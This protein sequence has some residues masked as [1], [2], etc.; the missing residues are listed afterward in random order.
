MQPFGPFPPDE[1]RFSLGVAVSGGA[2]SL[3]L[4]WLMRRWRRSM[5]AFVV[6]H[7]LRTESAIEARQ[8][9]D[10]LA[11]LDI[12]VDVLRLEG[13]SLHSRLQEGARKARYA[14]LSEACARYGILD[15]ALGHH[16]RDQAET[17]YLRQAHG[18]TGY[19]LAAMARA[20][21]TGSLRYLRPLLSTE[22]ARLRATLRA[23]DIQWVE[24]PSNRNRAFERVR[25][26]QAL[27]AGRLDVAAAETRRHGH[28]R[29]VREA[30][31]ADALTH[32]HV[33]P[34]GFVVMPAIP[35]DIVLLGRL[36]QM[37]SGRDYAPSPSALAR[38]ID[39]PAPC[40]LGGAM[41]F[42]A[43][44]LG[45]GWCLAREPGAIR[46]RCEVRAGQKWDGRF[47]IGETRSGSGLHV[48][49]IGAE[50]RRFR[51]A[52]L[53]ARILSGL[54]G[55]WRGA[56]LLATPAFDGGLNGP[57]TSALFRFCPRQSLSAPSLW[58]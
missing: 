57:D 20:R 2:D 41:L 48:A 37:V 25:I 22:P 52:Q 14:V 18:S 27:D 15:L 3:C 23:Q 45:E 35:C 53:P 24:D 42:A 32:M 6:D 29:N 17:Y 49:A 7:G 13:L 46:Q 38:L 28:D 43:G 5:R 9:A 21:E 26:R 11:G 12:P 16:A 33:D 40:T 30:A 4:A 51:T 8:T 19:G 54:P 50:S 44:R 36:W 58:G 1:A 47:T 56:D 31:L 10:R 55:L 39:S 34:L